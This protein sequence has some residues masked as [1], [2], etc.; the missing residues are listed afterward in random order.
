MLSLYIVVEGISSDLPELMNTIHKHQFPGSQDWIEVIQP[1][2]E[3]IRH[4][5]ATLLFDPYKILT[6]SRQAKYFDLSWLG[7]L[8]PISQISF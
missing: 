7:M 3:S 2:R 5:S 1:A 8:C 6:I 4:H